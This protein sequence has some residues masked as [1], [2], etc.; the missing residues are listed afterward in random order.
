MA[1]RANPKNFTSF[2]D[3]SKRIQGYSVR[4]LAKVTYQ[5]RWW[6]RTKN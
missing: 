6:G 4:R 3:M 5:V 1:K 2:F